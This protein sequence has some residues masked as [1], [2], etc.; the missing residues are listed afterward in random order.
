MVVIMGISA[1]VKGQ[2]KNLRNTQWYNQPV[3]NW[4]QALPI[5]NRRIG[6]MILGN[7][8]TE[9][10]QLNEAS[11][12]GGGPNNNIDSAA[13][14]HLDEVRALPAQKIP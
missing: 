4:N 2:A 11:I 14:P 12:W 1:Q 10:I 9:R 7:P 8:A 5:G 13:R 6:G 3:A